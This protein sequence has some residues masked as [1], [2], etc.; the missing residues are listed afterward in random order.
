MGLIK[1]VT[2]AVGKGLGEQWKEVIEANGMSDRTVFTKG[3]AVRTDGSNS[4]GSSDI[5]TNGSTI[6]V[7]PGQF[8]MVVDG[9]KVVDY[10]AERDSRGLVKVW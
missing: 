1:A 8:M 7:Y 10:T 3:T 2:N 5:V 6:H 9:G 4:K